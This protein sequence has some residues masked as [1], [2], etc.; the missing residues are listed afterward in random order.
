MSLPTVPNLWNSVHRPIEYVLN[1]TYTFPLINVDVVTNN[2]KFVISPVTAA[3]NFIVGTNAI[4]PSGDYAGTYK[5]L[6]VATG[7]VTLDVQY[8][9]AYATSGTIISTRVPCELW[10]G[11]LASHPGAA[12]YPYSKAA[13]ITAIRDA[14][15]LCTIDVSGFIKGI[16]KEVEAPTLGRDF[17]MSVPFRL[18]IDGEIYSTFRYALNGVFKQADLA[19]Y[20]AAGKILN[21]REPIHFKNGKTLYSMIWDDTVEYGEHIVNIAATQ[22]T[23]QVGGIGFWQIGSTFIV[24]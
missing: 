20:D 16:L 7:A 13:D 15:G 17:R 23:S 6:A 1:P 8:N 9:A 21:A 11:Y 3:T 14:N 2:V 4:I 18:L 24:Q 5:V 12:I 19:N 22:G 10:V